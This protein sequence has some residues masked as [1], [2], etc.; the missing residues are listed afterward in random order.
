M[1]RKGD[2][3]SADKLA[4]LRAQIKYEEKL[5]MARDLARSS[6]DANCFSQSDMKAQELTDVKRMSKGLANTG[7]VEKSAQ[8]TDSDKATDVQPECTDWIFTHRLSIPANAAALVCICA[9]P[10]VHA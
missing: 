8:T 10:C 6:K 5:A 1:E 9:I 7:L 4:G 3:L 2:Q